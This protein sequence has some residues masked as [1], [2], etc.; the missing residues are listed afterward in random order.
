M[1]DF[2]L[3]VG[4]FL[5]ENNTIFFKESMGQ[6]WVLSSFLI[7]FFCL[8]VCFEMCFSTS[9]FVPS[10]LVLCLF[11]PQAYLS[12]PKLEPKLK[13]MLKVDKCFCKFC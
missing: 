7:L 2:C 4:H 9:N 6:V 3:S 13:Q 11:H 1:S 10:P 12:F 5:L 8:F